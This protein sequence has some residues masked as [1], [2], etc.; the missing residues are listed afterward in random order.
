MTTKNHTPRQIPLRGLARELGCDHTTLSSWI[1]S[2]RLRDGVG[3]DDRGRAI[4]T[5]ADLAAA[6][7]RRSYLPRVTMSS[8]ARPL[9][10]P[11]QVWDARMGVYVTAPELLEERNA[12]SVLVHALVAMLRAD[13]RDDLVPRV[14]ARLHAVRELSLATDEDVERGEQ[15]LV[16]VL[17]LLADEDDEDEQ[18]EPKEEAR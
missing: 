7:F 14:V 12:M 5:D 4:V 18:P 6:A 1:H 11:Q 13:A 10:E 15:E 3:V 17:T 2:G 8:K 9:S 16:G